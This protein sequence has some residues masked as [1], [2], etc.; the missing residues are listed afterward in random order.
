MSN[1]IQSAIAMLIFLVVLGV[2]IQRK[3]GTGIAG[4]DEK[5]AP[6]PTS[7]TRVQLSHSIKS[8]LTPYH[9]LWGSWEERGQVQRGMLHRMGRVLHKV[10]G[11]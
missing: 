8:C 2:F 9:S 6:L 4:I 5:I 10:Y 1:G 3:T 11:L 7:R